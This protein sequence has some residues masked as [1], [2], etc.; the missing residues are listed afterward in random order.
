MATDTEFR[1][2]IDP[3]ILCPEIGAFKNNLRRANERWEYFAC[4]RVES[5]A[6]LSAFVGPAAFSF[7]PDA[8]N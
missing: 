1:S 3:G 8:K 7:L 4:L 5:V 2:A 6:N